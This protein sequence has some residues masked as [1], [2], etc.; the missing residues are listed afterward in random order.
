MTN[1]FDS[2]D[3]VYALPNPLNPDSQ[4]IE[5]FLKPI[6]AQPL[7]ELRRLVDRGD[8][9]GSQSLGDRNACKPHISTLPELVTLL[10]SLKEKGSPHYDELAQLEERNVFVNDTTRTL[11][12]IGVGAGLLEA[13]SQREA[14]FA[15]IRTPP[16][17]AADTMFFYDANSRSLIVRDNPNVVYNQCHGSLDVHLETHLPAHSKIREEGAITHYAPSTRV[18]KSPRGE[19]FEEGNLEVLATLLSPELAQGVQVLKPL[20]ISPRMLDFVE[21]GSPRPSVASLRRNAQQYIGGNSS[22]IK[23][24]YHIILARIVYKV[25]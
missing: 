21:V 25:E 8:F 7:G 15:G 24:S 22:E 12:R 9:G 3:F 16:T 4:T 2:R 14:S 18:L 5:F 11:E 17:L 13:M 6:G 1:V 10:I 19:H 20:T 23:N